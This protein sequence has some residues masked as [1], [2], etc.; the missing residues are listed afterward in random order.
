MRAEGEI[1]HKNGVTP[2]NFTAHTKLC[3]QMDSRPAELHLV[4][5]T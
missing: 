5:A 3:A 2:L 1:Q 4:A